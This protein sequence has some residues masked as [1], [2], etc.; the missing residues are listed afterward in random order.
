MNSFALIFSVFLLISVSPSLSSP[1]DLIASRSDN[2]EGSKG[3]HGTF[4]GLLR[5]GQEIV[6]ILDSIPFLSGAR[7][8][9]RSG[10]ETTLEEIGN[11]HSSV[12]STAAANPISTIFGNT[13]QSLHT[14]AQN[15]GQLMSN[16]V[17]DDEVAS[18]FRG[19][20]IISQFGNTT[21]RKNQ[22]SPQ[23]MELSRTHK[24]F[25]QQSQNDRAPSRET[26]FDMTKLP[27]Y[28]G[29]LEGI[30]YSIQKD[31]PLNETER[32][33]MQPS[34]YLS[35]ENKDQEEPS[36]SNK[37]KLTPNNRIL[38][39]DLTKLKN[40]KYKNPSHI[41]SFVNLKPK[42]SLKIPSGLKKRKYV[43][44][45]TSV[46]PETAS[47]ETLPWSDSSKNLF[48]TPSSFSSS[49]SIPKPFIPA[50]MKSTHYFEDTNNPK[51]D[52]YQNVFAN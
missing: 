11:L 9:I 33:T 36:N 4:L 31:I 1:L 20:R 26:S 23:E 52:F 18:V 8:F 32:K 42:K 7:D 38:K 51:F 30:A 48:S 43:S 28:K 12:S 22:G 6:T 2:E 49:S 41:T 15:L 3:N 24:R 40:L 25:L 19:N 35:N 50:E 21:Q 14:G 34:A 5:P 45:V 44:T 17:R 39:K 46:I 27:P 13:I 16:I 47:K 10:A 29:G 37:I